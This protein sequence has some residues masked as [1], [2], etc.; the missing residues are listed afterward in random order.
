VSAVQKPSVFDQLSARE[1]KVLRFVVSRSK[2]EPVAPGMCVVQIAWSDLPH[3]DMQARKALGRLVK[4][5]LTERRDKNAYV[6]T[7]A[8]RVV[9]Q[10]ADAEGLWR[11][12]P[13]PKVTN[14][15]RNREGQDK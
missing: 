7:E 1:V 5:G 10:Y 2:T 9:V 14:I 15:F 3:S 4:L 8:G 11:T 12:P 13:P 6:S